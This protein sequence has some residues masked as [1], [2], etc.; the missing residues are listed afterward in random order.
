MQS[1]K[2]HF[3]YIAYSVFF[4]LL[5]FVLLLSLNKARGSLPTSVS[6]F[7]L[8]L[9]ILATFRVTRLFVYDK[10]TFFLRDM[11]QHAEET[12][13][14]EGVTYTKKVER[15]EGAL[16]VAYELLTCPWCFSIW[17]ALFISYSYFLSVDIFWLPIFILAVSGFATLLQIIANMFGWIAETKKL[18]AKS[19]SVDMSNV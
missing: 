1:N 3:W 17:A 9:I 2:Q 18:E 11:L 8:T 15:R 7:D 6:A 5:A 14:R 4:L 13:T 12:Y 16:L 19:K 10:I